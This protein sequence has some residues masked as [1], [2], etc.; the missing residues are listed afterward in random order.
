MDTLLR[1]YLGIEDVLETSFQ[2][3]TDLIIVLNYKGLILDSRQSSYLPHIFMGELARQELRDVFPANAVEKIEAA[4]KAVQQTRAPADLEFSLSVQ[5]RVILARRTAG[6]S[7]GN[8]G[9]ADCQGCHK[10]S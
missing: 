9:A 5:D 1:K 6:F 7:F 4:L 8:P 3:F 2:A 10:M